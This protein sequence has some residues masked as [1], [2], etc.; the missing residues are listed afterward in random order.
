M[1][2][3]KSSNPWTTHQKELRY[4]NDWID[5]E[6]HN[7]T[8]PGGS[9]GVYGKVSFKNLALAILPIDEDGYTWIVGQYRYPLDIYSWELPMGG[10]LLSEAPLLSAQRELQEETG[11]TAKDW[12]CIMT[13]HTSNSVTD[14]TAYVYIARDL[15]MGPPAHEDTEDIVIKRIPFAE[16]YNMVM[17]GDI[18]DA[19]TV[20][21]V[22]KCKLLGLKSSIS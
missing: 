5:V 9:R 16:L 8:T 18:T 10:G 22:L 19:I 21:A 15:T 13:L 14:E 6:H 4:S 7:V 2:S 3:S 17:N 1:S 12:S 20:A 11:I